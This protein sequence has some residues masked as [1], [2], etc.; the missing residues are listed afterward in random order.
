MIFS[1][2]ESSTKS[3]KTEDSETENGQRRK[4]KLMEEDEV[5]VAAKTDTNR[6]E[7]VFWL[8]GM[9]TA[10][11][12]AFSEPQGQQ[13]S[14]IGK[15]AIAG[16]ERLEQSG[17]VDIYGPDMVFHG[18]KSPSAVGSE[19]LMNSLLA[20][21]SKGKA[22]PTLGASSQL[23]PERGL[24]VKD[25][26]LQQYAI[27][28]REE[29]DEKVHYP[30]PELEMPPSPL[31]ERLSET[32]V[33]SYEELEEPPVESVQPRINEWDLYARVADQQRREDKKGAGEQ[34]AGQDSGLVF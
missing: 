30:L 31:A 21:N 8:R 10:A 29:D 12:A 14:F 28:A 20:K 6:L 7:K 3:G 23:P 22:L 11:A 33:R 17:E 16:E 4:T 13:R 1:R 9:A 19:D 32:L 26:G 27:D 25:A 15:V 18:S 24:R 5:T 2:K 34:R